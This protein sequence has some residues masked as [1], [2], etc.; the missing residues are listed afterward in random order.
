MQLVDNDTFLKQLASLFETSNQKGSSIWLTHKRLTYEGE[1]AVMKDGNDVSDDREYPCILRATDGKNVNISTH[2]LPGELEKFHSAYGALL[3]GSMP[4]LR[5]RDKKR[6]KEKAERIAARKKL[7]TE[8]IVVDGSKRGSGRRKRQRKVK[9]ALK[10]EE[11]RKKFEER[12]K[13]LKNIHS[14]A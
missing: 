10:Q 5:K 9:A 11:S 13:K 4:S 2:V 1:D 14:A 8:P 7:A 3:K 6:E 12:Q